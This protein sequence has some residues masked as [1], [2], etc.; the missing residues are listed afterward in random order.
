M[1][2]QPAR[3]SPGCR[4]DRE[5]GT[6]C[7]STT[8]MDVTVGVSGVGPTLSPAAVALANTTGSRGNPA[9]PTT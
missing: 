9:G 7:G 1:P 3:L 2:K 4:S 6:V 8:V 5:L